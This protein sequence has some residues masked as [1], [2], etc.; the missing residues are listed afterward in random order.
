MGENFIHR[1]A[2]AFSELCLVL[3]KIKVCLTIFSKIVG[4]NQSPFDPRCQSLP[5]IRTKKAFW[6]AKNIFTFSCHVFAS[7]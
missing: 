2:E 4:Q 7:I 6:C 3:P 5:C 1:K